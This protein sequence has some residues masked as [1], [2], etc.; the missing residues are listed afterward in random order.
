MSNYFPVIKSLEEMIRR[1]FSQSL[2]LVHK[3]ENVDSEAKKRLTMYFS[4][5]ESIFINHINIADDPIAAIV[6]EIDKLLKSKTNSNVKFNFNRSENR[7][8]HFFTLFYQ[9]FAWEAKGIKFTSQ[10]RSGSSLD[11]NPDIVTSIDALFTEF[12]IYCQDQ[13]VRRHSRIVKHN[14]MSVALSSPVG[15]TQRIEGFLK[16][17]NT[18]VVFT[19]EKISEFREELFELLGDEIEYGQI[20]NLIRTVSIPDKAFGRTCEMP[21]ITIN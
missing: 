9:P 13:A 10:E 2:F 14:F 18:S 11:D 3:L 4:E 20:D 12:Q 16:K 6:S 1:L 15:K 21:K 17:V 7:L 8:E 19:R 5:Y